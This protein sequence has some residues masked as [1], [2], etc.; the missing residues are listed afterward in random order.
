MQDFCPISQ[1]SF[2][3]GAAKYLDSKLSPFT[4]YLTVYLMPNVRYF[5]HWGKVSQAAQ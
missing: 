5:C 1:M 2:K 4:C 3:L